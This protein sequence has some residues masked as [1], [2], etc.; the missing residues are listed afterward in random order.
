MKVGVIT[1]ANDKGQVVIPKYM[2]EKLGI[3]KKVPLNFVLRGEGIYI[4]P[5]DEVLVS[6]KN[7]SS[8]YLEM[9]KL[10]QGGWSSENW[11]SIRKSRERIEKKASEQRRKRW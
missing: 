6:S 10:T 1:T 7:S 5:V 3:N 9:L 2:R 4:Y 11:E 8:S